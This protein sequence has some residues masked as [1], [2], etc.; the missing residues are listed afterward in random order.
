MRALKT[1]GLPDR[2]TDGAPVNIDALLH[3]WDS[4]IGQW[5]I[6]YPPYFSM[7]ALA[8]NILMKFINVIILARVYELS[9]VFLD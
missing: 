1:A 2:K 7:L 6:N 8:K 4:Q 5:H 3:R 9:E